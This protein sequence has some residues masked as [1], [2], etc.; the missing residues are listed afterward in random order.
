MPNVEFIFGLTGSTASVVIAYLL[1]AALFLSLSG[2]PALLTQLNPDDVTTGASAGSL[3]EHKPFWVTVRIS[4]LSCA[5]DYLTGGCCQLR[6]PRIVNSD[7][8]AQ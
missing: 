5:A 8:P 3:M 1:P 2:R 7:L 4:A 6:A